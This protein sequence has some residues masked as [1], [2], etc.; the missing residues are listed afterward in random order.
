MKIKYLVIGLIVLILGYLIYNRITADSETQKKDNG[1]KKPSVVSGIIAKN[2]SFDNTLDIAG[3]IEANEQVE[4][5]SEV[6]GIVQKILFTEGKQVNKGEVLFTV[7]DIELRA[8]LSKAQ[9][10]QKL[11]SENAR[12]AQLLLDK[13]AI[14]REEFDIATADF[15][16]AKA[17][18]QLI[19]AQIAKAQ[20]R[21]PFTGTIG[22]R[23]ISPGTYVTPTTIVA[24]LVN[25]NQVKI[26]FSVPEKYANQV[27]QNT[28]ISFEVSGVS[29]K[30]T[31]KIYA[32]EPEVSTDTRT[33]T[34]RALANNDKGKLLPG[35]F[36]KVT[37]PLAEIKD[38]IIIPTQA[39]I[40]V[41]N[42][43]KVF[44]ADHG[45]AKEVMIQTSTRTQSDILVLEGLKPGDTVIT[46]G[47][48]QLKNEAPISVKIDK[49]AGK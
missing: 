46:T 18:T 16:S 27:L 2:E 23:A 14:S 40:P 26:T 49:I 32:I 13:E 28:E 37:L 45:K 21:A 29:G 17:E 30:H 15:Q 5:R 47:V 4:I 6:S 3:S 20:V 34:V 9:T 22:L 7:N 19:Q 11:A 12:R 35:T 31:A 39:V 24:K 44:I 25:S 8:Q 48:M 10:A 43:K 33:L 1:P 41:Q 36:A 38:A 42:G